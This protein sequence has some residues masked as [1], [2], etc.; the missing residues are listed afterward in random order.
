M[1]AILIRD[2]R[3][4]D[5]LKLERLAK[6]K[7]IS[8]EEYLRRVIQ[9]HLSTS[10]IKELEN[11]YENLLHVITDAIENN[12]ERLEELTELVKEMMNHD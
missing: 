9:I 1:P 7:C 8:R 5:V 2:M 3:K 10:S 12:S 11:K 6:E 4:E